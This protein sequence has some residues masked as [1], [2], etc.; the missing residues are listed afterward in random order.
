MCGNSPRLLVLAARSI[1]TCDRMRDL[2]ISR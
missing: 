2:Y 1:C